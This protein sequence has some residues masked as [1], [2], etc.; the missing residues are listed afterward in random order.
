M[1]LA[2]RVQT[3]TSRLISLQYQNLL[4]S[5]GTASCCE[6][7][8]VRQGTRTSGFV[9]RSGSAHSNDKMG[10]GFGTLPLGETDRQLTGAAVECAVPANRRAEKARNTNSDRQESFIL[11]IWR[12]A[13][14]CGVLGCRGRVAVLGWGVGGRNETDN[15]NGQRVVNLSLSELHSGSSFEQEKPGGKRNLLGSQPTWSLLRCL[16][17]NGFLAEWAKQPTAA[18]VFHTRQRPK[19]RSSTPQKPHHRTSRPN[20][21]F[22]AAVGGR[23][24]CLGACCRPMRPVTEAG[25]VCGQF[26]IKVA[27]DAHSGP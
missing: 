3:G 14:R 6:G 9:C 26:R 21:P 20:G 19:S 17:D 13:M 7:Q 15:E 27:K 10:R 5:R 12:G 24:S 25:L 2:A 1:R 18:A 11:G 22:L 4:V 16:Q 8:V 23:E